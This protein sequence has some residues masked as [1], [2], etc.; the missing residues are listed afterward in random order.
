MARFL[1]A[2]VWL[3][4]LWE[5][6][7]AAAAA[8]AWVAGGEEDLVLCRLTLLAVLRHLTNPAIMGGDVLTNDEAA[9]VL[10]HLRAQDG[11]LFAPGPHPVRGFGRRCDR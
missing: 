3:P 8:R 4:L 11:I 10:D 7:V 6:H 1:D 5:G 2:D 9:R